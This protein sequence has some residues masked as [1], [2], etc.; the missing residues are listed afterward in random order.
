MK[1][2]YKVIDFLG[3]GSFGKAYLAECNTDNNKYVIKQIT[4]EGMSDEEKRD[5]FNEAIILKK[6]DH[7]NII[8]FKEVFLQRK[9]K[10]A[11][12]IVTEFADGG[13]LNQ[14]IEKRKKLP[15]SEAQIL[16]YITQI[17]LALQHIH[18]KKI[19]H[20]D[21]KS[22]NI[23]LMKSGIVK[24]GDFG[25]AKGLQST[26]EKA[27]TFVGTPYF[28]SPEIISNKPYDAKSDIWALGVLLYELMTFKMPFNAV[29]LPLLSIKINR[30]VY[31]PPPSTYSH[32]IRDL[33]KKCL[34]VD[35][36]KRPSI[37]EIL[38]LSLIK[39]RINNFLKEVQYDQDL[40]NTIAKKYKEERQKKKHKYKIV[41]K[42]IN[43]DN[44]KEKKEDSK[45]NLNMVNQNKQINNANKNDTI[46][47]G[48]SN[49]KNIINE[50]SSNSINTSEKKEAKRMES[51]KNKV[52]AF[53][54]KQKNATKKKETLIPNP[55]KDSN[56][57]NSGKNIN[58]NVDKSMRETNFLLQKNDP[59]FIQGKKYS[60]DEVGK[61]LKEKG[62][63]DLVDEKNGNFDVEK[64][65]EDQYNQL[66][67]LNNLHKI[68]NN[69]EQDSDNELSVSSSMASSNNE[70]EENENIVIEGT[71]IKENDGKENLKENKEKV[72]EEK[73][74]MEIIRKEIENEIGEELVKDVINLLDKYCD[75]NVVQ[76]DRKLIEDKIKS[77]KTKGYEE[78]NL[79]N[80]KGK[81]DEIFAIL[82]KEKIFV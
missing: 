53:F 55:Q 20:R 15:F 64:M 37:D 45:N 25:I 16:D 9:P 43:K 38:K 78:K 51:D 47:M 27:R 39:K 41:N 35:P 50:K 2:T 79:E 46:K 19:I 69:L 17:C 54:K 74:E 6:L 31:K 21:L 32:E 33:L 52:G 5:T 29:S 40:H 24:L 7:P 48:E 56:N 72:N 26:W 70:K 67:L 34:T 13:D 18:K 11:L 65:N 12:N 4:L 58:Q 3:E 59:N 73:K 23:F 22:G 36:E 57:T 68:A 66:R 75:K 28:L 30:G 63:K 14:K 82:M 1:A 8:K 60:E 49:N 10:P 42:E 61:Q 44:D 62:Y 81:L 76:F 71:S 77:L 80:V